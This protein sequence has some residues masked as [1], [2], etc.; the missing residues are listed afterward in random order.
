MTRAAAL[1]MLLLAAAGAACA[2]TSSAK[3]RRPVHAIDTLPPKLRDAALLGREVFDLVD[4]AADYKGSHHGRPPGSLRQMGLDSLAPLFVRR[5]AV[6]SDS[7]VVTVAFRQPRG[8]AVAACEGGLRI[9]EE[10]TLGGGR[11]TV[12]CTTPSG[13]IVKYEVPA[14]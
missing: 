8:R 11:F 4:R 1:A 12:L 5:I 14:R 10:A 13:S 3:R 6:V 9:L 2:G 7:P